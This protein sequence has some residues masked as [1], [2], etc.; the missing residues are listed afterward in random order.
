MAQ[1]RS[2]DQALLSHLK[3]VKR[4][5]PADGAAVVV[6]TQVVRTG[7]A[8]RE[9]QVR[10]LG[11]WLLTSCPAPVYET[12]RLPR[13]HSPAEAYATEASGLLASVVSREMPIL[14]LWFRAERVQTINW[15]GNPHKPVD[16]TSTGQLTPRQ[17][18]EIW[19][20]TV[21]HQSRPW[22]AAEVDAARRLGRAL[23]DVGQQQTLTS[24]N[25]QLRR[26]L[27]EKEALLAK[28]MAEL[29]HMNRQATVGHLSASITHELNQP[30]GAILNNVEAAVMLVDQRFPDGRELKAILGDIKRDDQRASEVIKRLGHLLTQGTVDAQEVDVNEVVREVFDIL[31]ALAAAR[32]VKLGGKLAQQRLRVKGDRVQLE[33]VI[34]NL[35]VNG[36]EAIAGARNGIREIDCRSWASDGQALVSIR[37]S[38]PGIPSDHL[39]QLFEPF[40]T[41][42]GDGMGMGL[43][44][45]RTIIEAHGG[46]ISAETRPS[47]AVFHISLPMAK[48]QW[49]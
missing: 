23:F 7:H 47:G 4:A 45:A 14:L 20:E 19:K 17:S 32:D 37:N 34:L 46:K 31:S 35:V 28:R 22:S 38:G 15:A 12:S 2:L 13:E 8:P 42:K 40:F 18:F 24:L 6:G 49:A 25:V 10:D 16:A 1:E 44:I 11:R 41:T 39:E 30:L 21:R 3:D 33:Q 48:T 26:T 5:V 9:E 43:C 27:S 29:A 36:I